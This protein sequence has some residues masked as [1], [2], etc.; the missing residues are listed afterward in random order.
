MYK[1]K[2]I[3]KY[4]LRIRYKCDNRE[5]IKNFKIKLKIL[6]LSDTLIEID[7]KIVEYIL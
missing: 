2:I 1:I 6:F 3:S 7:F 5:F 4:L